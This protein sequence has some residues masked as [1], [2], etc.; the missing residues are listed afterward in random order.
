MK[1]RKFKKIK[2]YKSGDF[3]FYKGGQYLREK[4]DDDKGC[5]EYRVKNIKPGRKLLVCIKNKKGPRGGQT[6]AV[7]L[8]RSLNI[9]LNEYKTKDKLRV[10]KAL[11]K[12]K[13]IKLKKG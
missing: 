5:N 8:L 3:Y 9:P 6:K 7:A 10:K 2:L 13:K 4:L 12:F 1:K 11:K